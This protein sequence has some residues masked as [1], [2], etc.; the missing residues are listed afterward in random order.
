[1][2]KKQTLKANLG[3]QTLIERC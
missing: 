3:N 2:Y 1:L